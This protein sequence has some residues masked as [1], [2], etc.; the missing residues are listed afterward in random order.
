MLMAGLTAAT[1]TVAARF[2]DPQAPYVR[3][4]SLATNC[5]VPAA[6]GNLAH[7]LAVAI[8]PASSFG[9][10]RSFQLALP[11]SLGVFAAPGNERELDF[12]S[13]FDLGDAWS[14]VLI[15]FGFSLFAGV[16]FTTALILAFVMDFAY[17]FIFG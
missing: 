4:F 13:H 10:A 5:L 12:L 11:D 8:H 3:F 17:A 9:D 1:L 7:A 6:L 16:R 2:R 14:F 15:A